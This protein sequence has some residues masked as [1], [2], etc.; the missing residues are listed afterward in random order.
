LPLLEGIIDTAATPPLTSLVVSNIVP[1]TLSNPY[2]GALVLDP[3]GT[4]PPA[5]GLQWG[6]TDWPA[7]AG[8]T[9]RAG[10]VFE[11]DFLHMTLVY[12]LADAHTVFGEHVATGVA[13]SLIMFSRGLL[14]SIQ[15]NISPGWAVS[16]AWLVAP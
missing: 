1:S 14:D 7:G 9:N 16:F 11:L 8:M 12:R 6:V 4:G 15:V 5:Y 2:V 3:V 10:V 13:N